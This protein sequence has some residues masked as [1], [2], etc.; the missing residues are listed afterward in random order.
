M[1]AP[2][3]VAAIP[4]RTPSDVFQPACRCLNCW[5][6]A[7]CTRRAATARRGGRR[8]RCAFQALADAQRIRTRRHDRPARNACARRCAAISPA[9]SPRPPL[10]S[11]SNA[12]PAAGA[13]PGPEAWLAGRPVRA[14][15]GSPAPGASPRQLGAELAVLAMIVPGLLRG[16]TAEKNRRIGEERD[17]HRRRWPPEELFCGANPYETG[18]PISVHANCR[19]R[20]RTP[21]SGNPPAT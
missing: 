2:S 15:R 18:S 3:S 10:S 9:S 8:S 6:D 20:R 14:H 16:R 7:A 5:S 12:T 13:R 21:R 17:R 19:S 1:P 11:R 4:V